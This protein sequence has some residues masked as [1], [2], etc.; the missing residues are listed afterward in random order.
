MMISEEFKKQFEDAIVVGNKI[1][2]NNVHDV[3]KFLREQ[4]NFD[5]LKDITAVDAGSGRTEL[6]YHLYSEDGNEDLLISNYVYTETETI[7]DVFKSAIAD[8]NEIYDLFGIKFNGNKGLKRLYMP[9]DWKG[10]PLRKD[11]ADI[12]E[13]LTWNDNYNI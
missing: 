13:R 1:F 4:L 8:E 11:Y 3:I 9:E 10:F 12:D 2:V 6:I 7:T 5:L